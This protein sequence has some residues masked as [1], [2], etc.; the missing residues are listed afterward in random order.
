MFK[1]AKRCF[2]GLWD[3]TVTVHFVRSKDG[4]VML[5]LM[6][7]DCKEWTTVVVMLQLVQLIMVP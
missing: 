5:L 4:H 2:Y 6:G 7:V 3:G 1:C